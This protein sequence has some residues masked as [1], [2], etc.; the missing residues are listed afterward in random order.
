VKPWQIV[1]AL[2]LGVAGA[3]VLYHYPPAAYTF[4]PHC[5]FRDATGLD[6]PGCGSTR[7]LHQLLHGRVREAVRLNAMLFPLLLLGAF[8]APSFLRG[9]TPSFI[10]SRWFGWT[11]LV[12]VVGWWIARNV[13]WPN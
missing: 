6:C 7:A 8:S 9:R 5:A 3:W 2:I 4:Y 13:W 12:V 11:T 10:M 1:S